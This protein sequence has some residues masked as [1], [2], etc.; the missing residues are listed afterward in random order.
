MVSSRQ[1]PGSVPAKMLSLEEGWTPGNVSPRTLG[2]EGG[3]IVKSHVNWR[4][5]RVLARMLGPEGGG[6]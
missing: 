2:L 3:W 5:E 6:L 4:E 1:T